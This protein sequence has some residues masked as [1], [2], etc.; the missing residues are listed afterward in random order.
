MTTTTT[1]TNAN[2]PAS[3]DS[4]PASWSGD[5]AIYT[6]LAAD[7]AVEMIYLDIDEPAG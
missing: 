2:F 7:G 6:V 3:R 5:L 1:V 4:S